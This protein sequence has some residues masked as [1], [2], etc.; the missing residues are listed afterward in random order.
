MSAFIIVAEDSED[1][2][3]LIKFTLEKAGYRVLTTV[4]GHEAL[5][6]IEIEKPDLLITDVFMPELNGYE[7]LSELKSRNIVLKVI[8][9]ALQSSDE[10]FNRSHHYGSINFMQKPFQPRQLLETVS[11]I[12]SLRE[13]PFVPLCN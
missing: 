3:V 1:A 12:L 6:A 10:V 11:R 8:V 13:I 9:L 2:A 7:L 5:K 4:N